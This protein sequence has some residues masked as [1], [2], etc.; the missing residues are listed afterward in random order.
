MDSSADLK[1]H[2]GSSNEGQDYKILTFD[3]LGTNI[4]IK[5]QV[6]LIKVIST[7]PN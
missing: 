1:K 3:H 5:N 6:V 4:S 2:R 7:V